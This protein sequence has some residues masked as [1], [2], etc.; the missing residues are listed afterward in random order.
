MRKFRLLAV[1]LMALALTAPNTYAQRQDVDA[2]CGGDAMGNAEVAWQADAAET[3]RL[4]TTSGIIRRNK[5]I[6]TIHPTRAGPIRLVDRREPDLPDCDGKT[7]L[8]YRFEGIV[9]RQVIV[10][11]YRYEQHTSLI[12]DIQTGAP[13]PFDGNSFLPSPSSRYVIFTEPS[14]GSFIAEL[15]IFDTIGSLRA[16]A[17]P[18]RGL[19]A[20]SARW[21]N[22]GNLSL[23]LIDTDSGGYLGPA[24]VSITGTG[25]DLR[26]DNVNVV[27]APFLMPIP[28][29]P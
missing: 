5:N 10:S 9:G 25:I 28:I 21:Q 22:D 15:V 16:A 4:S 17:I 24:S 19:A 8:V 1:L 26:H 3:S 20:G 6:L 29:R 11:E 12:I 27:S 23:D 2:P 13:H 7:N 18:F 14:Y